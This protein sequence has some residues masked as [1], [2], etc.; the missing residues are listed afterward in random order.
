M[1]S[2]ANYWTCCQRME[3]KKAAGTCVLSCNLCCYTLICLEE[4]AEKLCDFQHSVRTK[5]VSAD[6]S[7]ATPPSINDPKLLSE[8]A[9]V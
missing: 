5:F 2:L 8:A 1:V 7:A 3:K 9:R 6:I 4:M